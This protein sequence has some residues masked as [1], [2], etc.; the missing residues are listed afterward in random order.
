MKRIFTIVVLLFSITAF[1]QVTDA[2][3]NLRTQD[4]DTI[5]GWKKGTQITLGLSQTSLTNWVGGG[6]SSIAAN[7]M[8]N[9]FAHKKMKKA[10]WEN[11]FDIGYGIL[12]QGAVA[13]WVKT[14]DRI[15]LTSKYGYKLSKKWY[16]AGL[17]NFKTQMT[18]GFNYPNDS[19][20]ISRFLAPGYFLGAL[21]FDY[22]PHDN[23][24]LF[25][26][27]ATAKVTIVNDQTLADAGAFGVEKATYDANGAIL[28]KGQNV[29]SEFG[30]YLR[31]MYK[32]ELMP[33]VSFMTK[34][35]L[36]S[37]YLNN[38]GNIDVNWETL[39]TL[40]VN[41]F[42]S[43]SFAT[44]LVYDDDVLI[45]VD[46][47]RNGSIDTKGPRTQFKQVLNVGLSYKF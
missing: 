13:K 1:G 22:K 3:K 30:G 28:T 14:D 7:G 43:A 16:L 10:L 33:N 42:I 12:R 23:F 2:E 25:I 8:V 40:K 35:D 34:L 11:Y 6:Q 15:E 39:L 17:L 26:A 9:L 46:T 18:D 31:L 20:K 47:D 24:S 36:F 44:Q 29:R 38:P 5:L 45:G 21:G 41:K 19:V 27:P 37:N 4:N 32:K